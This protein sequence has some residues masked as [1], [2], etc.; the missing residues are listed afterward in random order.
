MTSEHEKQWQDLVEKAA[1]D[2]SMMPWPEHFHKILTELVTIND[3]DERNLTF[4]REVEKLGFRAAEKFVRANLSHLPEVRELVEL[5]KKLCSSVQGDCYLG[6]DIER[7]LCD[8]INNIFK[9]LEGK[10]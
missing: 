9:K 1:I 5:I 8:D 4:A 7:D 10:K 3:K 6:Q 2:H